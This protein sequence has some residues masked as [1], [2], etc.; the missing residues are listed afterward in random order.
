MKII[1]EIVL[2]TETT[3]LDYSS[4]DRIIEIAC[5]ELFDRV[6]MGD[7]FH[8]YLNPKKFISS[9]AYK[10]HGISNDY[11]KDKP[12]FS[13]IC[14]DF[15]SFLQ[16]SKI[17]IHNAKFDIGF[18]NNEL[19]IIGKKKLPTYRLIDT[20]LLARKKFPGSPVN[21][22]ALCR[23]FDISLLGRK[24]HGALI[25]IK[26]LSQVYCKL[27]EGVQGEIHFTNSICIKNNNY[28]N[29]VQ[30]ERIFKPSIEEL[31]L[32]KNMIKKMKL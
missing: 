8:T 13:E 9:S 20:L 26:L 11:V 5:V 19:S 23:R 18:I 25:D 28:N 4:G 1:R 30:V 21:L 22:N 17:V 24:N 6:K 16:E 14:D 29:S 10:I 2:D 15:L 3:G 32:H 31:E 27:M 12:V 7:V